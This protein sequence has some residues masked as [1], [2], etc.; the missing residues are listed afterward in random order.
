MS[1]K[2]YLRL[3]N[4]PFQYELKTRWKDMDA[5]NHVNN[6]IFL[7]YLED[8]R[9]TFFKRWKLD[10]LDKGLIV[11]SIQIDF[12][13]QITHPSKL[14]IG[15]RLSRIGNKSFDIDSAIFKKDNNMPLASSNIVC[16]CFNYS[17]NE[18]VEVFTEIITDYKN[19]LSK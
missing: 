1:K 2:N 3:S 19:N 6:A 9:I 4:Y 8:A 13:Q 17:T 15:Q 7:T 10:S 18:S 16:V 12:I 11:A 14:I 5:F